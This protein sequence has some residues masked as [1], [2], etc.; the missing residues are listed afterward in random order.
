MSGMDETYSAV[1]VTVSDGV[2][3]G[4]REDVS[5]ATAEQLLTAAGFSLEGRH[6]VP[7]ERALIEALLIGLDSDLVVTTGG[8]G[9]GPRDV[10]PE[11]T[12]AVLEREAPGLVVLMLRAGLD[13]T[14]NAALSRAAAGTRGSTLILNLPGSPKGVREGLEAVLPVLPHALDLLKGA[15]GE[16]PS[17][18]PLEVVPAAAGPGTVVATVV[19]VHGDPPCR[20][21]NRMVIGPGG[22][23]SGTLG[24]SEFDSAAMADAPA[25]LAAE[26][27]ETRTY[28]HDLGEVDVFLEPQVAPPL[29]VVFSAT[30]VALELLRLARGLGYGT[31][32]VEARAERITAEHRAAAGSVAAALDP[33]AVGATTDAVHTDHDAP[34]VA[35]SVAVLLRTDARFIG[36]MGSSRHV[37]PHV[38]ALQTRG[39]TADDLARVHSPVGLDIGGST[40]GEI[41]LSIAAGLLASQRQRQGGWLDR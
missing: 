36:V 9:F 22:P 40:P 21:G 1:V 41:A 18:D 16:H 33:A 32:L 34:G 10:T 11:A 31:V 23:L 25:V 14:P 15:T 13:H 7:D 39:F 6:V 24:C 38:V 29:L 19:K 30:P 5:G 12:K 17:G 26:V 4:T 20:V 35:D 27:P 3:A 37:A 2:A 8:T 28:L